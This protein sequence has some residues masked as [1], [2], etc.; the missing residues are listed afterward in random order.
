MGLLEDGVDE[1]RNVCEKCNVLSITGALKT[2]QMKTVNSTAEVK[3]VL[4]MYVRIY[5]ICVSVCV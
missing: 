5:S 1:R 3:C 4:C 2:G